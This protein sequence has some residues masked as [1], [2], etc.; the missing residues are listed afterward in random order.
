MACAMAAGDID[1]SAGDPD[2]VGFDPRQIDHVV[3]AMV[4][5]A[6]RNENPLWPEAP[7]RRQPFSV[8]A[9]RTGSPPERAV[10][11]TLTMFAAR[12]WLAQNGYYLPSKMEHISAGSSSCKRS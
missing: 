10:S 4:V 11:A 2:N 7:Q 3:L 6:G 5:V 9:W 1:N 8:P 12:A